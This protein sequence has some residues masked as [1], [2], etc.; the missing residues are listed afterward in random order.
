MERTVPPCPELLEV[1]E[2]LIFLHLI[3]SKRPKV[4]RKSRLILALAS[5][6]SPSTY[7]CL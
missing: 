5:M 1:K 7:L 2:Y 3:I 6:A 4:I